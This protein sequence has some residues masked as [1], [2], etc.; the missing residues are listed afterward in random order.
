MYIYVE[1]LIICVF[2][3]TDL[4]YCICTDVALGVDL[5]W[6]GGGT[7]FIGE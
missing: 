2:L 3:C 1:V 5:T 7:P 4:A 6:G